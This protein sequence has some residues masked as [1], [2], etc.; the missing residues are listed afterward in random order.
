M[1][2]ER[3]M[4]RVAARL[5]PAALDEI[6][7]RYTR[8]A[9]AVAA[10][11]LPDAAL[12]EDAVQEALLRLVRN[13]SAYDASRPFAP[14]F[15]AIVRHAAVDLARR[16]SRHEAAVA[17]LAA[18]TPREP[19][20]DPPVPP[21]DPDHLLR[22]VPAG[23]RDVLVLRIVEGL[24]FADVAAALDISEEAAKK[25]AQR[26]LSRLRDHVLVPAKAS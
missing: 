23:E 6:V 15:Y 21:A 18:R 24:P 14:W 26:G 16:R 13:R 1:S 22:H 11:F 17:D 3:L 2:D 25:R 7:A 9:L 5:D 19:F 10:R 20:A 12:A 4:A 8:P